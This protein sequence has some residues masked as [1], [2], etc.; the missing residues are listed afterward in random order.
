MAFGQR[1]DSS[2]W[3]AQVTPGSRVSLLPVNKWSYVECTRADRSPRSRADRAS[4][5]GRTGSRTTV[6]QQYTLAT[7]FV[8]AAS[9]CLVVFLLVL[10]AV[11][12]QVQIVDVPP[13][14]ACAMRAGTSCV[15]VFSMYS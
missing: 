10:P 15:T 8:V 14:C 1:I 12:G 4:N 13:G 2:V 11:G 3:F 7:Y 6:A 9:V 5:I